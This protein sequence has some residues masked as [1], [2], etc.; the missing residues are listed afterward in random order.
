MTALRFTN[1]SSH[2]LAQIPGLIPHRGWSTLAKRNAD[3][4]KAGVGAEIDDA[5][6]IIDKSLRLR[7][8]IRDSKC[9]I[10]I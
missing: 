3:T 5:A 10:D 4:V 6:D 9:I 8:S 7:P 1:R 2:H